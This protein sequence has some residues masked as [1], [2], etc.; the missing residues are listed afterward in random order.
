MRGQDY[1]TAGWLTDADICALLRE[2][3]VV[4]SV[5]SFTDVLVLRQYI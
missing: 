2:S 1:E 3:N 4:L 5:P